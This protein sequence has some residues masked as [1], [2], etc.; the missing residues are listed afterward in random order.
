MGP[1]CQPREGRRNIRCFGRG[2]PSSQAPIHLSGHPA[3][4]GERRSK[5]VSNASSILQG[6]EILEILRHIPHRY[7]FLLVDRVE[8]YASKECVRAIKNVSANDHFFHGLPTE[9]RRMPQMLVVEAVAQV[10]GMLCHYSGLLDGPGRPMIFLAGFEDCR[11][12]RMP[13]PGEQLQIECKSFRMMRGIVKMSGVASVN[14]EQA[15]EARLTA[16]VV[17]TE[18]QD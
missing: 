12:G 1:G 17:L 15:L 2:A 8:H 10:A 16:A 3:T 11:F 5:Q 18:G 7:P 4:L 14:G 9:R 13:G 6:T